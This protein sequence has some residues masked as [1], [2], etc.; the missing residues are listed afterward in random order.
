[1]LQVVD[2]GMCLDVV[3]EEEGEVET[4]VVVD[5]DTLLQWREI[6]Q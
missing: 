5:K 1:M 2:E 3:V 6:E 4:L